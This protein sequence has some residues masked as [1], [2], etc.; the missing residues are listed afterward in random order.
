MHYGLFDIKCASNYYVCMGA[1]NDYVDTILSFFDHTANIFEVIFAVFN[2]VRISTVISL[3]GL[4][5]I[6]APSTV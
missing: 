3:Y 6:T 5:F 1:F 2:C 4:H